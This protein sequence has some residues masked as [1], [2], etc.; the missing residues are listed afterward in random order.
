MKKL[1]TIAMLVSGLSSG[2]A[3]G[4]VSFGNNVA[5][6][7]PA[8]TAANT[9]TDRLV[10][11]QDNTTKLIGTNYKAQLYYA[12]GAG[13]SASSLQAIVGDT[14]ASFRALGTS[15]PGTWNPSSSSKTLTG[16]LEGQTATLQVRVWDGVLFA[17]YALAVANNGIT[18][19][20]LP[21]NYTVP[22][23]GSAADAYFMNGLQSFTVTGVPEPSTIALGLVGA[24]ALLVRRIRRK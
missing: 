2:F 12:P 3:Q 20:S 16:V 11:D 13:Q 1:L 8:V 5:F 22:V 10:Y 7:S 24:G 17:N 6:N 21:F 15:V 4:T 14:A 18:G 23:A 9:H 19:A